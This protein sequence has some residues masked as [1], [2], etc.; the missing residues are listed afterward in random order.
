MDTSGYAFEEPPKLSYDDM[1][2]LYEG[3]GLFAKV[4]DTP[5]EEAVRKAPVLRGGGEAAEIVA[6]AFERIGWEEQAGTAVQWARLFGG[7]IAVM[8]I[9]DGGRLEDPVKME[10]VRSVDDMRV[11]P[12]SQVRIDLAPDGQPE[13]FHVSSMYGDFTVDASRC[14]TFRNDT[15]PELSKNENFR[16]WGIPEC[17]RINEAVKRAALSS[18]QAVK[19]VDAAVLA[20]YKARGLSAILAQEGGEELV[21]RRLQVIDAARSVWNTILI[22]AGG[23]SYDFIGAGLEG[24][25]EIVECAMRYLAAVSRIP[26]EILYGYRNPHWWRNSSP[27][28]Q[29]AYYNFVGGIQRRMLKPNAERLASLILQADGRQL[30]RLP[31]PVIDFPPL[32]SQSATEQAA[33]AQRRAEAQLARA[34][35]IQ[36]YM[37]ADVVGRQ[38]VRPLLKGLKK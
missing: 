35:T 30:S 12:C 27:A 25:G 18:E 14:L 8:L 20:V 21:V 22:D 38:D 11:Y 5:A 28:A 7:A 37:T 26:P 10:R 36:A 9:D 6:E 16:L 17:F 34:K 19:A 2:A 29:E 1:I 24:K 15:A 32:W 13:R 33:A 4:I 31:P 23:E 3:S